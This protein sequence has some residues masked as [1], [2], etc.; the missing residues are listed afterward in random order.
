MV[1]IMENN[2]GSIDPA[3]ARE[4]LAE[5]AS[6]QKAVRDTPWPTWLYP[7]NSLLLGAVG[8]CFLLDRWS[9]PA[10]VGV[11]AA[12]WAVNLGVGRSTGVP[13]ALPTSKTFLAWVAASTVCLVTA[14]VL[15]SEVDERW[16][17]VVASAGAMLC[18][19]I[20]S[21]VHHRSTRR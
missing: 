6:A 21:W 16:P 5:V 13:F 1:S 10:L 14:S 17:V 7:V 19:A 18:Y 3:R 20:A 9:L 8:L 12:I 15:A 4:A 2:D 11:A